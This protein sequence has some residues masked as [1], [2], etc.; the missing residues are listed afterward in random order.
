MGSGAGLPGIPLKMIREDIKL[1]LIESIQ[2]KAAFLNL[3]VKELNLANINILAERAEN[4][5]YIKCDII[6]IRL[7][8]KIK[9][10]FPVAVKLLKSTGKII[11]Y[12]SQTAREEVIEA[13]KV[14]LKFDMNSKI[15]E[16]TIPG[17]K[18]VRRLVII[19]KNK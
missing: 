10:L 5:K 4:I 3:A 14:L 7:L 18:I 19:E 16:K 6:L 13:K 12:K 15:I 2:K 11:F 8:G 9:E 17:T 1:Y